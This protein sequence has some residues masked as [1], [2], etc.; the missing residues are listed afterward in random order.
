GPPIRHP[1]EI[2]ASVID[3]PAQRLRPF[4][5]QGDP[6]PPQFV[7]LALGPLMHASGQWSAIGTLL[8][9]G[10][11]VLYDRLHVDMEHVL[12]LVERERVN[13]MN[14]VGDASARPLLSALA[15]H[16]DRWTRR[17]CDCS[18][19]AGASSPATPRKH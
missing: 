18:V 17:R 15:A 16:R 14:L 10:K 1:D 13:A 7:S 11:V 4:L 2:T 6:G 9:G 12:D 3:N 8:G 19:P 5:P